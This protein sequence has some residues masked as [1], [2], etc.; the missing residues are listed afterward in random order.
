MPMP[1]APVQGFTGLTQQARL[2]LE[3]N[4]SQ[5]NPGEQLLLPTASAAATMSLTTQPSS[6]APTT[7]MHLHF[8]IQGNTASGTIVITGTKVGGGA[9]TSQ[10]YH[11]AAAPQNNQGYTEFT[12]SE[13]W[14]TVGSGG[15]AITTIANGTITVYGSIAAKYLIPIDLESEEKFAKFSPQDKRGILFK[16]FRVVQLTK[17]VEIG[18]IK[19]SLYG[20]ISSLLWPYLLIGAA[21][22]I[23][24]APAT[25]TVKL[26]ATTKASTMTLTTAP[27]SPG[28]LLIFTITSNSGG[29][30]G[31]IA[32]VGTDTV[33]NAVSETITVPANYSGPLYSQHRYSAL[34]SPGA[35]EF[36]TTGMASGATVAVGGVFAY[37]Y[38]WTYDGLTNP[39]PYSGCWEFFDG[40]MGVK[41]PYFILQSGDFDWQKE[42]EI[43]FSGKGEAQDFLIVGDPN[44]STYPSGTNPFAVLAQPTDN[45]MVSWP[46][47]FYLDTLPGTPFTTQT[48]EFLTMKFGFSNG[49]KFFYSGDGAQR[50][51]AVT[52]SEYPDFTFEA[53]TVLQSYAEYVN[54]FKPNQKLAAGVQFTGAWLGTTSGNAQVYE[55]WQ[56]TL[57]VKIDSYKRDV[58]KNPVEVAVKQ[59]SEYDFVSL[60][61]AFKLAVTAAVAP[62]LPN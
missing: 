46:G 16:N 44:P 27:A 19:Q 28:E 29:A 13:V 39:N 48:G 30:A 26:A 4:S 8:Y 43:A 31:T 10:T 3:A 24:T 12:T 47:T 7:G 62:T 22:V 60:G 41:L 56:W 9:Q 59:M 57:P 49:Q 40:M 37:V 6:L 34:T 55:A 23:T 15:I 2:V 17:S 1:I 25:P 18:S 5:A 52:R 61:Y 54:Y 32:L 33:G 36:A 14:A 42:K 45:P 35:N 58:T 50:P 21:P 53:T 51:Q 11:V 20:G 38:T